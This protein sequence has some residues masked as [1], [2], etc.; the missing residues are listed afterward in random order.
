MTPDAVDSDASR[1]FD[2]CGFHKTL[3]DVIDDG[4]D[5]AASYVLI[6]EHA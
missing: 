2:S 1:Q 3:N 5:D 6:R 4:A